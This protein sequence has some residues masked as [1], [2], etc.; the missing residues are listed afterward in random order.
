MD[1]SQPNVSYWLVGIRGNERRVRLSADG[2]LLVGRG[3]HNHLVLNDYRISRQHSRVA[4]ERD[5]FVVYDLNSANGT[6]V[7]GVAVRRQQLQPNDE[8]SFGPHAF[9][10]EV[11]TEAVSASTGG[12]AF[13][14]KWRPTESI[15]KFHQVNTVPPGPMTRQDRP[16]QN[17]FGGPTHPMEPDVA[18]SAHDTIPPD[19]ADVYDVHIPPS[20]ARESSKYRAEVA[21]VDLNQLEDAYEKLNTLYAFMQAISK[22]IDRREL[23]DLIARRILAIYPAARSVGIYL[24]A[25]RDPKVPGHDQFVLIHFAGDREAPVEQV[26][27]L[28]I[29]NA[30]VRAR[31]AIFDA[32]AAKT[33]NWGSTMYAPMLDREDTLGIIFVSAGEGS[34]RE[35]TGSDLELLN[36]VAV[37][38]AIT[39]VN[40]RMHEESLQR[41]RLNRD[42]EL[43]AQIQKSFLPREVL[44]VPGLECLATYKAAYT[45]GGDFYDVFWVGPDQLAVFVGDI[46][47]K[48][49]AA[50]LL[51]ARISGEL[52]VAALA[53][54]DPVSVLTIMNKSVIDRNQ[55]EEFFTAIYFTLDVKTGEVWL[56][57]AGQP[58]PYLVRQD[59][60]IL[61]ITDGASGAVGMLADVQFTSTRLFL[62]DGDSLVL[63]TDGVVE[64]AGPDGSL[65]GNDR[66]AQA[67]RGSTSKPKDISDRILA[68]VGRHTKTAPANDDMTIFVCHRADGAPASMQPRRNTASA[69]PAIPDPPRTDRLTAR[70]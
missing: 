14:T 33:V 30:V 58:S 62:D 31:R 8:I 18:R 65:F 27:P 5:G 60:T 67:L 46:S 1:P 23:L 44:S 2:P 13:P 43:A 21:T 61:E 52:R 66:L 15:T 36:G 40:T 63:Y 6:F 56:A 12:V 16:L 45:V 47:G 42:L 32:H 57:T 50:A 17:D 25:P 9:R 4:H 38:A 29:G 68:S 55:P 11:Q 64:A 26:L 70:R 39:M 54:I 19:A 10:V 37:P 24:R 53:H 3:A 35:F 7:N 41:E 22:T 28:A 48:G 59:G 20:S 49:I 34:L 51:M 69:M